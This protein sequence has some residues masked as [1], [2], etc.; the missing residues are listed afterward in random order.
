MSREKKV[1]PFFLLENSRL[2]SPWGPLDLSTC[3]R[4]DSLKVIGKILFV[5]SV[6]PAI[7]HPED[8]RYGGY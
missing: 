2:L 8:P 1:C 3:L 7:G 5:K 4:N 6:S